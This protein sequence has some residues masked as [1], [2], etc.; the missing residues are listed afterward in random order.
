MFESAAYD[1]G[2]FALTLHADDGGN[3]RDYAPVSRDYLARAEQA[4]ETLESG[5]ADLIIGLTHLHLAD[6]IEISKLKARHPS[7][8]FIVG[9]HEHEP[10]HE[11]AT[12]VTAEVMKGASNAR[13]IW[14]IDV[15]FDDDGTPELES[16]MIAVDES[17]ALHPG[18][19]PIV[20][21]WRGRLLE[22]LPFLP[23]KIGVAAL[24]L[25]AREVTVRNAESNWGNF[26]V[27]QMLTAFGGPP[28][29][30][31]FINAGTLRIDDYI[32]DEITFEDIGRTFGF[33]SYLRY[34]TMRGA[35]FRDLLEAGYRGSG[36]SKGYFPQIAGFRVCVDRAR[37]DGRRIVQM[38]V[39][40]DETWQE[41]EA[42][43]EYE[44]VAPDFIHRGGDGYDFSAARD[45]SRSG[46]E[47]QYLV[48]DAILNAQAQ[49]KAV[50]E[51]VDPDNPRIAFLE[52]GAT[53]CFE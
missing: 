26:I 32:A 45:V 16:R 51:P 6:D 12:P 2:V 18:Y 29:E 37:P 31:A 36:P 47:L 7:F 11:P 41:I 23:A 19:E 5:G 50:G 17:I 42:D 53:K 20:E 35:E 10:E 43:R 27:D 46:S 3:V 1:I 40:V 34:M 38:Q 48:L 49:G 44:V 52:H 28:A 24:P 21:K 33:S 25:D 4:I 30:L 13:T 14:Q 39:P 9:G 22:K 8:M 15:F